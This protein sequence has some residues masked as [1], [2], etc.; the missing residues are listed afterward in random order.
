MSR[1]DQLQSLLTLDAGPNKVVSVY[2]DTDSSRQSTEA[3]R[4]Q[5]RTM[6]KETCSALEADA[7]AIE[8]Y[9]DYS[10]D[11]SKPG[12]A[13]FSC[14]EQGFFEAHPIAVSFRN[15]VRVADKPYVKHLAHFLDYYATYGVVLV[16]RLGVRFL[17]FDLGELIET[18]GHLGEEVR[19]LKSGQGPMTMGIRGGLGGDRH[20]EEV[21]HRNMREA[22]AAA[23]AFFAKRPVRRLFL[24]GQT[25]AVSEF[26]DLL[27]KQLQSCIAGTFNIDS[28]ATEHEVGQRAL[29]LL[30]EAN[31]EREAK[32]VQTLVDQHGQGGNAVV[33][34]DDTL[35]AVC[36]RRVQTL[37]ISDGF[38]SPGYKEEGMRFVVANLAKS[39]L[40]DQELVEVND[41][42]E[43]AVTYTIEQGGHV[44]VVSGNPHLESVGRIGAILRY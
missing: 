21:A 26:R 37:L 33:G 18:E 29:R 3:I 13:L 30:R 14:A 28:N 6:L 38:R 44:E 42:V 20:E 31:E 10:F 39:P 4:L 19:R 41:V 9:L 12:L 1:Q 27:P 23:Q 32:L 35:Q 16:D 40:S 5:A 25:T 17:V 43:T 11:W 24:G 2:L 7:A 8:R 34:L 22:A 15:R 36:D